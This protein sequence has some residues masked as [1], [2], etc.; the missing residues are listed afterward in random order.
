MNELHEPALYLVENNQLA[1]QVLEAAQA[2]GIKAAKYNGSASTD[3]GFING[4]VLLI[5][6]YHSLLLIRMRIPQKTKVLLTDDAIEIAKSARKLALDIYNSPLPESELIA[7][8]H[9][10]LESSRVPT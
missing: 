5:G 8:Y 6:T 7:Q 2:F 1:S 10:R 9:N 3:S 4:E